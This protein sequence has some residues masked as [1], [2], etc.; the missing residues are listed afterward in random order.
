[1][2][3]DGDE[4]SVEMPLDTDKEGNTVVLSQGG[5]G[6]SGE[7]GTVDLSNYV[8]KPTS[9]TSW[10]VYKKGTGWA[11]V[12][13]DLVA[14]NPEVVFRNSKGQ[15]AST[16]EYEGLTNQLEV[17]RYFADR[18]EAAGEPTTDARIEGHP[19]WTALAGA[20]IVRKITLRMC[21]T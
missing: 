20:T 1:M 3:S 4:I 19:N 11:P 17:N 14:T 7:G 16:E 6:S 8:Q 10:M 13:T 15:F 12:T 21:L 9:N 5:S 18:L 2:L